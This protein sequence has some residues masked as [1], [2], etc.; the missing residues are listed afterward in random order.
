MMKKNQI[1]LLSIGILAVVVLYS[2]PTSVVNNKDNEALEFVDESRPGG[3][4]IDHSS[5]IPEEIQPKIDF[6][7]EKL[8]SDSNIKKDEIALDSLMGVFQTINQYDSAAYYAESFAKE[9]KTITLWQKAGDAY[10]EAFTF[11]IEPQKV[12]RLGGKAR[13]MYAKVL[14][15]TPDNLDV[16]N[17]LAMT[18]IASSNPMQGIMMLREILE[19]DDKNEKALLNMGRLSMQSNQF[20]KAVERFEALVSYHPNSLDGN[21][22]LAVCYFETGKNDKAKAQFQKV[23]N[24]DSDPVVQTAVDEYLQRIK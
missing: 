16:K 12:E 20:D 24:M 23:K 22:L 5:E 13:E 4:V 15:Q 19:I 14:E 21:Y 17:N 8:V 7:K 11:A 10:F 1:I 9:F 3:E 18:Y 6:W 2:L